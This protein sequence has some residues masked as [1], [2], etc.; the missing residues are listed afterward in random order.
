[1]VVRV[2]SGGLGFGLALAWGLAARPAAAAPNSGAVQLSLDGALV[3]YTLTNVK[4]DADGINART[5]FT[6]SSMSYGPFGSGFGLG[7][8]Y[9]LDRF[10][11]GARAQLT[12][13][14]FKNDDSGDSSALPPGESK[15]TEISF[16][17]RA[18]V[19]FNGGDVRAFAAAVVGV[20]RSSA[21][22]Q[23][24]DGVWST[25]YLAGASLGVHAFLSDRLSIDPALTAL[26]FAGSQTLAA[27]NVS[28]NEFA[29]ADRHASTNG[30][31]LLFSVGLSAWLGGH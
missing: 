21:E 20:S 16:F 2:V 31:R 15:Q 28:S 8:G 12:S 24:G 27:V 9:V 17:P 13:T 23:T 14:T 30:Y 7:A 3:S 25:S 18:E 1:M 6:Q 11:L 22:P 29:P 26:G 5:P 4:P 19:L 10:V